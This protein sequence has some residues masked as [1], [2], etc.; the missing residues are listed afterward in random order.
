MVAVAERWVALTKPEETEEHRYALA[1][2]KAAEKALERFAED[3]KEGIY[4]GAMG[5]FFPR[6]VSEAEADLSNALRRASDFNGTVDLT[7]FDD[8]DALSEAWQAA[9]GDLRRDLIRLAIDKVTVTRG[10]RRGAPF[11]GDVRCVITWAAPERN[12]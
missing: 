10:Q 3:R 7:L 6:I 9:D 1:A 11:D 5:R 12:D 8:Y 4:D 2:V